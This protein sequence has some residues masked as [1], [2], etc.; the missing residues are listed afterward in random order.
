MSKIGRGLKELLDDN[1]IDINDIKD[2]EVV[3]N[4]ELDKIKPNPYQPRKVFDEEKIDELAAS[5]SENGVFQ[6]IIVKQFDNNYIIVSGE[7]RFRACQKLKLTTIPAIVRAYDESKVAEIALIENLQRENLTAMEEAIAYQTIMR[8]LGL[9]QAELAK[10]IGKSRSY[11][12]NVV[13]LLSLPAE[14]ANLVSEGKI[15]SG[16]ARP[17]SKL[18]DEKRIIEIANE[19]VAKN[20]NVRDVEEITK[21]EKKTKT[22][23]VSSNKFVRTQNK[24]EN[25]LGCKVKVAEDKITIS[26]P[27]EKRN[28][29]VKKISG[30][31]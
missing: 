12:T 17:L 23:K 8:E 10:K 4:I 20:L 13:G 30:D 3:L 27:K 22:I 2:G 25:Y 16:H 31:K 18:K 14:V 24:L 5:I 9:T 1:Y 28:E 26:F 7:R 11:I 21:N 29:I 19:I 15:T 6:P